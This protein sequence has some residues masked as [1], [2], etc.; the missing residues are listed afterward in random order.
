M[1]KTSFYLIITSLSAFLFVSCASLSGLN[2]NA[3]YKFTQKYETVT[4]DEKISYL[5]T[6]IKYP[7]FDKQTD[8]N[9]RIENSIISNWNSFKSYSKTEWEDITSLNNRGNSK[10]PPFEYLVTYEVSGTKN[11]ISIIINT[12]IF[13]GGA[14]G[15]TTL[16]AINYD[17]SKKAYINI[18][19]ATGMN[20]NEISSIVRN[21]LYKRLID[22]NRN[23]LTSSEK[24]SLREMINTGAFPQAGNYEIFSVD[25]PK[26]YSWFE[27]Y[28]V[29]PY[30]YG[31]QKVQVK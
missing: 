5:D 8:L 4:I 9:K 13:N 3:D 31:I 27:P 29:A 21:N 25:G 2:K 7:K 23:S 26:V 16:T 30:S 15:N 10:L 1:T 18:I 12:Y 6:N 17:T 14:H 11:I 20:Y 28:S 19:Q 24:D 22:N